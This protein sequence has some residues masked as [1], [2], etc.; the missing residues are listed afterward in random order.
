VHSVFSGIGAV[1]CIVINDE[2]WH[3]VQAHGRVLM[4][5]PEM[6]IDKYNLECWL[7]DAG[8]P[9]ETVHNALGQYDIDVAIGCD[10]RIGDA[11]DFPMRAIYDAEEE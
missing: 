4:T 10:A 5:T 8:G 7:V 11:I 6:L 9:L 1:R 2:K 3:D